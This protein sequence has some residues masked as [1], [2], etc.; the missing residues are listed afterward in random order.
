[1]NLAARLLAIAGPSELIATD[2]VASATAEDHAWRPRGARP[3]RGFA[4][5]VQLFALPLGAPAALSSDASP[6]AW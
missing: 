4:H 6:A 1:V 3:I 5:P 2:A